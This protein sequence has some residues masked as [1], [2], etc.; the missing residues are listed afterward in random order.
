MKLS[1]LIPVYNEERTLGKVL[2]KVLALPLES[3]EVIVVNDGSSDG[4]AEV[5]SDW[6]Q[7]EERVI[8]IHQPSNQGKTA[9]IRRAMER[10]TGDIIIIQDADLEYDPV[11]IPDVIAPIQQQVADVVY[12]SR[13]LVKRAARVLYFYHYLANKGLTLLSNLLTNRNMSDIETCYKAFRADII[14]PLQL[15]S[16]GFGMEIEITAMI[17][18]T[19]CRTYEVPISYYGRTYQEGKKVGF[20]D[21]LAALWYILYFNLVF[22]WT[23][24]GKSYV[25]TVNRTLREKQWLHE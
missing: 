10:A 4:T 5:L 25:E 15:T 14:K 7:R 9:A 19:Q 8:A 3:L 24:Q 18:K 16:Q 6:S 23:T 13:F 1:I 12:G 22:P 21:G 17:C 20:K 2:E 11:E